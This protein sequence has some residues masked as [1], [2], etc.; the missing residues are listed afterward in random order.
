MK[1]LFKKRGLSM[2]TLIMK[3]LMLTAVIMMTLSGCKSLRK[4]IDSAK[5]GNAKAEPPKKAELSVENKVA[6]LERLNDWFSYPVAR[7]KMQKSGSP[8][9]Q[10]Y[11]QGSIYFEVYYD[12]NELKNYEY[13]DRKLH[14]DFAWKKGADGTWEKTANSKKIQEGLLYINP[15][16]KVAMYY[17]PGQDGA[18]DVFKVVIK[19]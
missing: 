11:S 14:T 1:G 9:V 6:E 4:D 18:F 12:E 7:N 13:Y 17:Y 15:A 8:I 16:Y 2:K 10:P 3:T 19:T 5:M